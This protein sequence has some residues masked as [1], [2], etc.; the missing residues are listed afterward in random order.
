MHSVIWAHY[1]H[2][3]CQG[4]DIISLEKTKS[5]HFS[6]VQ[7]LS[8][9]QIFV[10][11]GLQ[12]NRLPCPSPTPRACSNSCPSSWW[13]HPTISSS[14]VP[15]SSCLQSF[16]ASGYFLVSQFFASSGQ[17]TSVWLKQTLVIKQK[18]F[19]QYLNGLNTGFLIWSL[20]TQRVVLCFWRILFLKSI[21]T[22]LLSYQDTST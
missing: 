6:S 16:L 13:C 21:K 9:V 17:V 3:S 8:H 12:H 18:C 15:F 19:T 22:L 2:L 10:T 11:H 1:C 14:V 5:S 4:K 20:Q 7:S